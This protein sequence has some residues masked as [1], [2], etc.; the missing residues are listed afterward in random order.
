MVQLMLY[1]KILA[2]S[3]RTDEPITPVI[4][5][6]RK[7][8]VNGI[9]KLTCNKHE[10]TDYHTELEEFDSRFASVISDIFNPELPFKQ[11]PDVGGHACTFCQFKSICG[12]P[13]DNSEK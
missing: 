12:V 1:C 5:N 2:A 11:S 7:I 8:Y 4:Y 9:N 10:I 6:L 13:E 3:L